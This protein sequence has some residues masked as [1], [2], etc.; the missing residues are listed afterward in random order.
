MTMQQPTHL[1]HFEVG[2][3]AFAPSVCGADLRRYLIDNGQLVPAAIVEA[4][5][6]LRVDGPCLRL[7]GSEEERRSV[8]RDLAA[9]PSHRELPGAFDANT[10]GR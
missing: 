6:P 1:P 3:G 2:D 5:P 4:R 8:S 10:G 7:L 9:G